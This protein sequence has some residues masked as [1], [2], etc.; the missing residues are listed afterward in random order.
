MSLHDCIILNWA[1]TL[2]IKTKKEE[3]LGERSKSS[4]A[5]CYLIPCEG[6]PLAVSVVYLP[7]GKIMITLLR[8]PTSIVQGRSRH[9]YVKPPILITGKQQQ[10]QPLKLSLS[11]LQL[12]L[13]VR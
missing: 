11:P 5:L 8:L 10:S 12:I 2:I 13:P 3:T 1:S 6:S 4:T 7:S 9:R